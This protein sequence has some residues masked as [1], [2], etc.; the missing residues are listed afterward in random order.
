MFSRYG[1]RTRRGHILEQWQLQI[2]AV[3]LV[4]QREGGTHSYQIDYKPLVIN[5]LVAERV[6]F[7]PDSTL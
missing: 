1:R 4:W 6:G 3:R 7:E 5:H 2:Y